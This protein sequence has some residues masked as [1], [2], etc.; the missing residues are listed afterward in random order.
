MF[1]FRID[2]P[3]ESREVMEGEDGAEKLADKI[4]K[5]FR[6]NGLMVNDPAVI[7]GIAGDFTDA[8]DVVPLKR[9]K[10]GEI[11]AAASTGA[12]AEFLISEEEFDEL[13]NQVM[14]TVNNLC[15]DLLDGKIDIRP[16]MSKKVTPCQ[17]CDYKGICR[18]DLNFPGCGYDIVK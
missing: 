5:H 8:S 10:D 7:D 6:M 2:D 13:R 11:A 12:G 9:K 4:R 16:K 1:Y 3:R 15:A 17:Y 18:F 14:R